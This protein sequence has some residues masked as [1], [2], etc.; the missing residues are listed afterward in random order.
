VGF[1]RYHVPPAVEIYPKTLDSIDSKSP[2][3]PDPRSSKPAGDE[4]H[5]RTAKAG[6]HGYRHADPTPVPP[7]RYGIT[8]GASAAPVPAPIGDG[9]DIPVFLRRVQTIP[10]IVGANQPAP[11]CAWAGPRSCLGALSSNIPL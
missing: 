7:V 8:V 10:E 1:G 2:L 4:A 9:L 3:T 5:W 6:K 11:Q